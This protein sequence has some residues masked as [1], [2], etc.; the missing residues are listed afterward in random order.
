MDSNDYRDFVSYLYNYKIG[1][2]YIDE[3]FNSEFFKYIAL[4]S[5]LLLMLSLNK[6]ILIANGLW[7]QREEEIE[8]IYLASE[9]LEINKDRPIDKIFYTFIGYKNNEIFEEFQKAKLKDKNKEK[10]KKKDKKNDINENKN[11]DNSKKEDNEQNGKNIKEKN[12]NK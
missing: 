9:R 6:N 3:G 2:R 12:E 7:Y 8:N 5:V 4:D 1:I 10:N 11:D